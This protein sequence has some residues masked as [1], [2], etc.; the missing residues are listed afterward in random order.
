[1]L[2][3]SAFATFARH[4]WLMPL[5]GLLFFVIYRYRKDSQFILFSLFAAALLFIYVF[6]F[7]SISSSAIY[8]ERVID[9]TIG[10]RTESSYLFFR[11]YFLAR[12]IFGYGESSWYSDSFI[13]DWGHE[14]GIHV[15]WFDILYSGGL[16]GLYLY[17]G[18]VYQIYLKGR[19]IYRQTGNPIFLV[20]VAVFTLINFTAVFTQ[21]GYYGY[22]FMLFYLFLYYKLDVGSDDLLQAQDDPPIAYLAPGQPLHRR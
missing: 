1:M 5:S 4:V 21:I 20:F 13:S 15:G 12:P 7:D 22:Y 14:M 6:Y 16:V 10:A 11:E 9:D 8:Q 2:F 19:A 17:C 3:F 18:F